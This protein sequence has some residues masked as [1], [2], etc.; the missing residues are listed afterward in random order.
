MNG[1]SQF[2]IATI[3]AGT[4]KMTVKLEDGSNSS[5]LNLANVPLTNEAGQKIALTEPEGRRFRESQL[6]RFHTAV[7]ADG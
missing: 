5:E 4:N 7:P 3:N 2:E 1:S 6:R